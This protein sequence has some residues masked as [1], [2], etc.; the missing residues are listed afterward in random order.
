MSMRL[1]WCSG[2]PEEEETESPKRLISVAMS[3]A[4]LPIPTTSTRL[5]SNPFG[6]RYS[7]LCITLPWNSVCK[8]L[9]FGIYG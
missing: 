7:I 8:P 6:R 4:E 1:V 5:S 2:T 9:K 3:Q